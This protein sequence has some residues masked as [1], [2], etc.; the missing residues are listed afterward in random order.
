MQVLKWL[1]FAGV[2]QRRELLQAGQVDLVL[3][4]TV[5]EPALLRC[6]QQG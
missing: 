6:A 4:R 5:P 2:D 3:D 1:G